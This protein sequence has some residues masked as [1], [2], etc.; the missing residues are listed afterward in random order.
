[1]QI[2]VCFASERVFQ[3][4][5]KTGETYAICKLLLVSFLKETVIKKIFP[6]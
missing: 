6:N 4:A 3:R 1:M 5:D 2:F